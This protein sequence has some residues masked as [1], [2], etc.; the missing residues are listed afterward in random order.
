MKK[1]SFQKHSFGR[2][3]FLS[4]TVRSVGSVILIL[5]IVL[6][7]LRLVWPGAFVALVSPL[8]GIG[9]ALTSGIDS[10]ASS[11]GDPR[12]LTLQRDAVEMENIQLAL[13]LETAQAQIADMGAVATGE[14]ILVGV[15]ARPPVA[16]YDVLILGAGSNAGVQQGLIVYGPGG[17]PIG[18][19]SD[20]TP[21][22]SRASLFSE[23][24]RETQGWAGEERVPVTLVGKGS[25]TFSLTVAKDAGITVDSLVY[26][27][28]PGAIPVG[29]VKRIDTDP[30]TPDA[31]VHVFPYANPFSLSYVRVGPHLLP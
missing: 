15:L 21:S 28:G 20:A 24:G 22:S 1:P 8:W 19:I 23:A 9:S 17:T 6:G 16:P 13:Q 3:S 27:P 4:P 14:G 10:A 18:I 26:L 29:I 25:G 11:F 5:V 2:V 7:L 12:A 31:H 30:S